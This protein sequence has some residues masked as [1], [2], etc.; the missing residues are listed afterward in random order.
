LGILVGDMFRLTQELNATLWLLKC[1]FEH[2]LLTMT[3][4]REIGTF[5]MTDGFVVHVGFRVFVL[6]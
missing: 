2:G 6:S 4:S 1:L 3:K 5:R